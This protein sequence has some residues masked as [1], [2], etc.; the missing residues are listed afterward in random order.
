[1]LGIEERVTRLGGKYKIHSQ[2][3]RGTI[4]SVELRFSGELPWH[5]ENRAPPVKQIR[6]L[7]A[8]DHTVMRRGLR[9]LLESHP[10]FG[11]VAE[12]SD[13]RQAAEQAEARV[14]PASAK[15]RLTVGIN[16]RPSG[17]GLV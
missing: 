11:V 10:E 17:T 13:G 5:D 8:D 1:M 3:E 7:L 12:A 9:L 16:F 14:G 4:L 15:D 6:I 2:P